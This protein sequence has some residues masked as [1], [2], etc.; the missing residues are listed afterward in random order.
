[1]KGND[2]SRSSAERVL[3]A[4]EEDIFQAGAGSVCVHIHDTLFPYNKLKY[5][6]HIRLRDHQS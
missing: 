5:L 1:M 3:E 4:L 6:I 2:Q